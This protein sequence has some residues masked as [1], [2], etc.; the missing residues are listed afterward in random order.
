MP[1]QLRSHLAASGSLRISL[2]EVAAS[3]PGEQD[4]VVRIDAAPINP[5]DL[6]V[7]LARVDP[8]T[9][10]EQDGALV[11]ELPATARQGLEARFDKPIPV[12]NEGAGTVIAAG[13]SAEAQALL[14]KTVAIAGGA[15]FAEQRTL[16]AA[17]CLPLPDGLDAKAG[18]SNF[19]NPMTV[20]AMLETMRR[21]GHRAIV[22]TA[23]ASNLGLM[24]AKACARDEVPLVAIVRND[25]QIATLRALGVQHVLDSSQEGFVDSLTEAI[26]KT[27]ATLAFDAVGGG[28]LAE[29]ILTAME[30]ALSRDTDTWSPYGST[31]LK[32]V[33]VYGMLDRGPTTLSRGYGLAWGFGGWLVGNVLAK[34]TPDEVS[35]LRARV[36]RELTTTFASEYTAE[37]RLADLL[38][39]ATLLRIARMA[40]GE[41]YLIRA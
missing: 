18:A 2:D 10:C 38:D 21:E 30:R 36:A 19:V 32:Q 40:T 17:Q 15:T 16:P 1:L 12:G 14:G 28:P 24:L 31:V 35:A 3:A 20:L 37:I 13:R 22:H 41:K 7:L 34:L 33:Y 5:S 27:G 39:H 26:A 6:G 29:R 4:V 9:L 25:A 23:A 8:R 11:G